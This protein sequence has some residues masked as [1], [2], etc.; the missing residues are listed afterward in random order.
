M[1]DLMKK[2]NDLKNKPL[3]ML[4]LG[5]F[6]AFGGLVFLPILFS[7]FSL[8]ILI[9]WLILIVGGTAIIVYSS[10]K[11]KQFNKINTERIDINEYIQFKL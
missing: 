3:L 8:P 5:C 7:F 2:S 4:V 9:M 1:E 10:I 6:V 11:L